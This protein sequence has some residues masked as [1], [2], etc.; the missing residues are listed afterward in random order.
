M[1]DEQ[2]RLSRRGY[3]GCAVRVDSK[4]DV[5]GSRRQVT[6]VQAEEY[7]GHWST[8]SHSIPHIT[9]STSIR[10]VTEYKQDDVLHPVHSETENGY[11]VEETV[12]SCGV[13]DL[14]SHPRTPHPLT[15]SSQKVPVDHFNKTGQRRRCAVSG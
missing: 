14:L 9:T 11:L 13:E 7:G 2:R 8:L 12:N 10:G 15:S 3:D 6:H 1:A 5:A 4:P